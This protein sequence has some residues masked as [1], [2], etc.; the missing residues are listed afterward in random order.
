MRSLFH[1][2]AASAA[3]EIHLQHRDGKYLLRFGLMKKKKLERS[4]EAQERDGDSN[5]T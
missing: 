3:P 1:K 4:S 2:V 5:P